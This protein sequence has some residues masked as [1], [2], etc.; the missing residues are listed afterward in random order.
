MRKVTCS[1]AELALSNAVPFISTYDD[2]EEQHPNA[3]G[4]T[5]PLFGGALAILGMER[6]GANPSFGR[7]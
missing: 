6:V 3:Q 7:C 2:T 5:M 4:G 1:R